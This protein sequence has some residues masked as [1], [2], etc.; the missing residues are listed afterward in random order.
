MFIHP[1]TCQQLPQTLCRGELYVVGMNITVAIHT[2]LR[3]DC[4]EH[5]TV[6]SDTMHC[7]ETSF[8]RFIQIGGQ[9]RT[10]QGAH[11]HRTVIYHVGFDSH[12]IVAHI[13]I[14]IIINVSFN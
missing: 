9:V 3:I 13:V 14:I 11:I 2:D 4:L 10:S 8:L 12:V 5:V 6:S 1:L 7:I